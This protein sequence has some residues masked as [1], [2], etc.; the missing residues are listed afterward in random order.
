MKLLLNDKEIAHFLLSL[1]DFYT[2]LLKIPYNIRHEVRIREYIALEIAK[3]KYS[4][5]KMRKKFKDKIHSHVNLD[6]KDYLDR[7]KQ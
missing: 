6:S 3:P 1:L 7:V 5:D 4:L 2:P